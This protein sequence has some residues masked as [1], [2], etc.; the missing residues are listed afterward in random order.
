[1]ATFKYG[2]TSAAQERE[3]Q[4]FVDAGYNP[5]NGFGGGKAVAWAAGQKTA[6][7]QPVAPQSFQYGA[8]SAAQ[9]AERAKVFQD[10]AA[11]GGNLKQL[12]DSGQF[13]FGG[14]ALKVYDATRKATLNQTQPYKAP[15][16]QPVGLLSV[17]TVPTAD[18]E[19]NRILSAGSPLLEAARTRGLGFAQ[20]RGLLNSS[21]AAQ[22]GEQAAIETATPLAQTN[23]NSAL[24]QQQQAN[25]I[26]AAAQQQAQQLGVTAGVD[27]ARLN[28]GQ[29]QF[30]QGLLDNQANRENQITLQGMQ[31]AANEKTNLASTL[32]T[33]NAQYET[34][35]TNLNNNKDIP[36]D[37]RK[38]QEANFAASRDSQIAALQAVYNVPLADY[39]AQIAAPAAAAQPQQLAASPSTDAEIQAL[40]SSLQGKKLN[41]TMKGQLIAVLARQ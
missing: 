27:Y 21:L 12:Y 2:A 41:D 16:V 32:Q 10:D 38:Q 15:N 34:N 6:A 29:Q 17:G 23:V 8:T 1:M 3:R 25:Q 11:Q 35:I 33:I 7:Q 19:V 26:N 37:V 4:S 14:G 40:V 30:Q 31:S 39:F 36:A 9:E 20:Q 13:Q 5:A 28:Q 22:A 24:Q 18:S